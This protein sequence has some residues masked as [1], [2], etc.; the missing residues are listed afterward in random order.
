MNR[1]NSQLEPVFEAFEKQGILPPEKCSESKG[2]YK[3]R[4]EF[5]PILMKKATHCAMCHKKIPENTFVVEL[6]FWDRKSEKYCTYVCMDCLLNKE[7]RI[8]WKYSK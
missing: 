3:N 2:K 1:V 5:K 7:G 4:W 8:E 6:A